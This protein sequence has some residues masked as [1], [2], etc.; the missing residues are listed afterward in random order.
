MSECTCQSSTMIWC[1]AN[2]LHS[3]NKNMA[4]PNSVYLQKK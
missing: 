3:G 2:L 4:L 1:I